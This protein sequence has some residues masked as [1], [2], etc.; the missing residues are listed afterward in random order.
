[1]SLCHTVQ[2]DRSKTEMYQASSPDEFS[3]VKFCA[4]VGVEY[5]GD[6]RRAD[7]DDGTVVRTVRCYKCSSLTRRG[8]A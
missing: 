6:E 7:D 8:S 3:F 1:M 5:M 2:V 4:R